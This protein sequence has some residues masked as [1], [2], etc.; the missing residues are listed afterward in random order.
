MLMTTLAWR[1]D[2][3]LIVGMPL[4]GIA[5]SM[6]GELLPPRGVPVS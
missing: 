6:A 4:F 1:A 3:G 2:A 5:V